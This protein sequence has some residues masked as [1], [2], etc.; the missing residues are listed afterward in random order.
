MFSYWLADLLD[1]DRPSRRASRRQKTRAVLELMQL[2]TRDTP[3]TISVTSLADVALGASHVGVTL[4][5][6]VHAANTNTSVNGSVAGSGADEIVFSPMLAG[7]K[8]TLTKGEL[9]LNDRA[10][11]TITGLG[12]DKL[13]IDG[14]NASRIFNCTTAATIKELKLTHGFALGGGA[15]SALGDLTLSNNYITNNKSEGGG[16]GVV[17]GGSLLATG[18]TI[19]N[20]TSV[21][22]GGGVEVHGASRFVNCTIANNTSA[23]DTSGGIYAAGRF[24]AINCTITGNA[25]D[26]GAGVLASGGATVI[27]SIIAG[28]LDSVDPNNPQLATPPGASRTVS[29]S[30]IGGDPTAIM[31][32]SVVSGRFVP[33]LTD[34]G[35]STPTVALKAGGPAIAA[36]ARA[37]AHAMDQRGVPRT[38]PPDIGAY[39]VAARVAY[40]VHYSG[41]VQGVGFRGTAEKIAKDYPV[42]G[43][44][45]NLA[46]RRVQLV[47]EG[48]EQAVQNFLAA[49]R[50]HWAKGK[51]ITQELA[52]TA[53][54]TGEYLT[55]AIRA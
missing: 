39:Q 16:G 4:R 28:N 53:K 29:T 47:V 51:N 55:F 9:L 22:N 2:E 12:A 38:S 25:G 20:N 35:G 50:A 17:V 5:D 54:P 21:F 18:N 45:K 14:N 52:E 30:L 8:I 37:D 11:T 23:P 32:G 1:L 49:I 46:D 31:A 10:G 42:T 48:T 44:V 24:T 6:A 40:V 34:N 26:F 7:K 43:W 3:A 41:R 13:T 36:G 19:A 15:I 33:L 27:N